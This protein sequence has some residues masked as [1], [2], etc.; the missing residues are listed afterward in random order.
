VTPVSQWI[1][2]KVIVKTVAR[3]RNSTSRE[4]RVVTAGS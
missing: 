3:K 2:S 1:F 4:G